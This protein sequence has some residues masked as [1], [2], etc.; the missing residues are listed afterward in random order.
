MVTPEKTCQVPM[1]ANKG[2]GRQLHDGR[3][4]IFHS[5]RAD[6]DKILFQQELNKLA[7]QCRGHLLDLNGFIFPDGVTIDAIGP[8]KIHFYNS[9]FQGKFVF[10]HPKIDSDL[11]FGNAVFK[12]GA[13]FEHRIFKHY[14]FGGKVHFAGAEFLGEAWFR[15]AVF[16][17]DTFLNAKFKKQAVFSAATFE[18]EVNFSEAKF[19]KPAGFFEVKFTSESRCRF[20]RTTFGA[21]ADFRSCRFEGETFF[22]D[23][24]SQ[25]KTNEKIDLSGSQISGSFKISEEKNPKTIIRREIDFRNVKFLD[26][27]TVKFEKINLGKFRFSGTDVRL[28][29]FVDVEWDRKKRRNRIRDE[30]APD[31]LTQKFEYDLIAQVYRRLRANYEESRNYPEAGDFYIGEMEMRRRIEKSFFNK[32]ALTLYRWLSNYGES[33]IC[34]I[35]WSIVTIFAFTFGYL[36]AGLSPITLNLDESPR[37]FIRYAPDLSSWESLISTAPKIS[38]LGRSFLHSCSVFLRFAIRTPRYVVVN[39]GGYIL[40]VIESVLGPV[41]IALLFLALRRRFKR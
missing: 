24:F 21:S 32:K 5:E 17:A 33:W 20:E 14:I 23:S 8:A 30:V 4:C 26:P 16:K 31:P 41:L 35:V 38:D 36:F 22:C 37:N 7:G 3:H 10:T 40:S 11:I 2:C 28:I 18:K 12:Q 13:E 39:E 1:R 19:E 15:G 29:E 9:I 6:K 34:P 27:R 25:G